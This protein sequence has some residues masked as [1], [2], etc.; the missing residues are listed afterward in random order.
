MHTIVSL[1]GRSPFGPLAQHAARVRETVELIRPLID[2]FLAMD[3]AETRRI[4]EQISKLEHK[5]DIAKNDIRDHLPKSLFM[6]VDRGDVLLFLREQDRIADRAED[7]GVLLTMRATPAPAGLTPDVHALVE[8]SLTTAHAWLDLATNLPKLEE[9][10]FSGPE[11][12]RVL[13]QIGGISNLEW[14]ADKAQAAAS[15]ALFEFEQ[16]IGAVSVVLWMR[17]LEVLGSVADHA[18]NT[19]DLLRVMLAKR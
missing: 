11:V 15:S 17:I 12:D 1:F 9:A 2:A 3:R 18:E 19:A 13:D 8:A 6:P 14:E 16:E 5:A 10:S 7:L 4:Y